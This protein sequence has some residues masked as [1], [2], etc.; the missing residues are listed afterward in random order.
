MATEEFH[1]KNPANTYLKTGNFDI[2]LKVTDANGCVDVS[3]APQFIRVG[4]PTGTYSGELKGEPCTNQA[5]SFTASSTNATIHRW[6][7]GDGV[8]VDKEIKQ[9]EHIY[10][11]AG[12]Y[13]TALLLIDSKGC[14]AVADG[15]FKV[16]IKDTTKFSMSPSPDCIFEGDSFQLEASVDNE[17]MTMGMDYQRPGD[18]N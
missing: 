15:S 14:K 3:T 6:D 13:S 9:A 2:K 10:T 4:G 16:T 11:K 18:W 8:V 7:F 1:F 12:T 17:E 5:A